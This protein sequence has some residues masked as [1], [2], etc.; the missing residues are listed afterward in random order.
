[1]ERL[2]GSVVAAEQPL[3]FGRSVADDL[4]LLYMLREATSHVVRLRW[5]LA[6][7]PLFPLRTHVHLVP[8]SSGVGAEAADYAREWLAGYRYGSYYYRQGPGFVTVKDVRPGGDPVRMTIGDGADHFLTMASARDEHD[9][10]EGTAAFL[11][12]AQEAGLLVR[13]SG[14]FLVLPYRLRHWPVPYA[15][16]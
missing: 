8:P 9:L 12:T 16:I 10:A 15:S 1:M 5:T 14:R 11:D 7:I 2:S 3:A 13:G 6:G 4:Q